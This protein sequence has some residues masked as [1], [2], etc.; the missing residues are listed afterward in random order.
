MGQQN[1]QNKNPNWNQQQPGAQGGKNI[2][3]QQ[4]GGKTQQRPGT[5][6][7]TNLPG[8]KTDDTRGGK[9][10]QGGQF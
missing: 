1:Q 8:G 4:Q 3:G 9:G 10:G 5:T 2:P 7:G 6:T